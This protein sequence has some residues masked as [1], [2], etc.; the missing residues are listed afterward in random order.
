MKEA[1]R[2]PNGMKFCLENGIDPYKDVECPA[3]PGTTYA[4]ELYE[5]KL[6]Q[7]NHYKILY[8]KHLNPCFPPDW[9]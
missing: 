3:S 4:Y 9:E 2:C 6:A 1:H 8:T 5:S 7:M